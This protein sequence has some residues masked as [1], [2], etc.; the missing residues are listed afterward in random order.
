M[1][2][3]LTILIIF[4]KINNGNN[5]DGKQSGEASLVL[6]YNSLCYGDDMDGRV[7]TMDPHTLA[8]TFVLLPQPSLPPSSIVEALLH[9]C[10]HR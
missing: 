2:P 10:P 4:A 7:E 8:T 9:P 6:T 5:R 3:R 1:C